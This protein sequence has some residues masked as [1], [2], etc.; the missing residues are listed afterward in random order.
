[1]AT[2]LDHKNDVEVVLIL[3]QKGQNDPY[4]FLGQKWARLMKEY[5]FSDICA[6][7]EILMTGGMKPEYY[8]RKGIFKFLIF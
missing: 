4:Y 6:D 2:F 1:M 7:L 3:V 8:I 5:L